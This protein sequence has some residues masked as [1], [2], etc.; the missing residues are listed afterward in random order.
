MLLYWQSWPIRK[1]IL[2]HAPDADASDQLD[3]DGNSRA[4]A[5]V[6]RAYFKS[7]FKSASPANTITY[8]NYAYESALHPNLELIYY[9]LHDN[10]I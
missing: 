10:K 6:C 3:Q 5:F 1:H 7:V 8:F 4:N 2:K 9:Y